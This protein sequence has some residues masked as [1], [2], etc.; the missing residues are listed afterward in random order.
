ME[1]EE[2]IQRFTTLMS[3]PPSRARARVCACD[4]ASSR[5]ILCVLCVCVRAC[6]C[7]RLCVC[8]C[9]RVLT[10]L[11]M[12]RAPEMADAHAR[13]L[14]GPPGAGGAGEDR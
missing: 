7:V 13:M 14:I 12:Y 6:V 3:A 4:G 2:N 9:L 5:A 11:H 10:H 8:V 1:E